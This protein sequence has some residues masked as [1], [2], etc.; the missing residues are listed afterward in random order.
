MPDEYKVDD[1]VQSYR[2]YYIG[3]K[4][5]HIQNGAYKFTEAPSWINA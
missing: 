4:V 1:P 2:N 3:E 5:G